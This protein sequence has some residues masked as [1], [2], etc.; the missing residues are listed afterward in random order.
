MYRAVS[1]KILPFAMMMFS[2]VTFAQSDNSIS[3]GMK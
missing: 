1:A 3:E 2:G